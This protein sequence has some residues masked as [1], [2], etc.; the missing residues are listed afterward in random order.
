M[1]GYFLQTN[2][3]TVS[4]MSDQAETCGI[5]ATEELDEWRRISGGSSPKYVE[6]SDL[7]SDLESE[8]DESHEVVSIPST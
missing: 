5:E 3:D 8:K 1:T 7:S 2:S 6:K 4:W